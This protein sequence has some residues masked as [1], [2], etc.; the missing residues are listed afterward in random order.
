MSD[1]ISLTSGMRSTLLFLQNT[2]SL[3][4]RTNERLATGNKVN[5]ALDD[6]V[7][8]FAAKEH[9]DRAD[10]LQILKD[11]MSEGI[12]TIETADKAIESITDL[13][14]QAESIINSART[15]ET[16]DLVSLEGQW[17]EL[18]TQIDDLAEDAYYKGTNLLA[19]DSLD[20][21]FENAHSLTVTGFD[22]S[23][24]GLGLAAAA[25]DGSD[26]AVDATLDSFDALI[27]TAKSTLRT[28]SQVLSSNLAIVDTREDFTSNMINTLLAGADN[29]V[30]A[31]TT[32]EGANLLALQTRQSL[33]SESLSIASDSNASVLQLF[34]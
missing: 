8:Y 17:N 1:R 23:S 22:G 3:M 33:C 29:L 10:D 34:Q 32:E 14:D 21:M 11:N 18:M 15:A 20:V 19:G 26:F 4:D 5:S 25:G 24:T 28:Q 7:A 12:Q 9:T 30:L 13:L 6:P 27:D 16:A 31:D 2:N